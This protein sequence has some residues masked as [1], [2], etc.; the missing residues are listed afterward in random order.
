MTLPRLTTRAPAKINLDLA[1]LGRRSDGYHELD[2]LVMFAG[3]G[4]AMSLDPSRP[5]GLSITGPFAAGLAADDGNLVLKAAANL[6][7]QRPA[8]R[9]GHFTLMKRLPVASG[10]GG[11]SADAAAALR[12]LSRLNNLSPDD[13]LLMSAA[14]ATGADVPVCL[15]SRACIMSGIGE[16]LEPSLTLPRL[17]AVLVN[18]GVHVSTAAV[19]AELGLA[20]GEARR[21]DPHRERFQRTATELMSALHAGPGNDLEAPARSLVP[22]IG[23]LLDWLG[24]RHG[25][26]SARMSALNSFMRKSRSLFAS[27][28]PALYS[29]PAYTSSVFSRKITTFS[30]SGSRIGLPTPSK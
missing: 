26:E 25:A 13:A 9:T 30:F 23:T 15:H 1:I 29:I 2:S 28:E 16:R 21:G 20:K 4:D 17:F 10:I 11:G 22:E 12:L 18:P 14:M 27:A 8:L 5:L 19:F 7:A 24:T 3:V 6:L